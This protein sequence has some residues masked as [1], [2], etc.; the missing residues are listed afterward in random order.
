MTPSLPDW[1]WQP[2]ARSRLE[3]K[4]PHTCE[5]LEHVTALSPASASS[6]ASWRKK[7]LCC[8]TMKVYIALLVLFSVYFS[9]VS[10]LVSLCFAFKTLSLFLL[11][12]SSHFPLVFNSRENWLMEKIFT[13]KLFFFLH[14]RIHWEIMSYK[15][16]KSCCFCWTN[17]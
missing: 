13:V 8:P 16:H 9:S 6:S 12:L 14:F 15:S 10:P 7:D 17:L 5:T 11:L 2:T 1:H 4:T 3:G